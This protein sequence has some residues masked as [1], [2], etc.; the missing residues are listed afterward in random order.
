MKRIYLRNIRKYA[1]VDDEDYE[2]LKQLAW[3]GF[4]SSHDLHYY[5]RAT[6]NH[7]PGRV[8]TVQLHRAV[9]NAQPGEAVTFKNRNRLDCRKENLVIASRSVIRQHGDGWERQRKSKYR[10]VNIRE[11]LTK[12]LRYDSQIRIGATTI[13]LGTFDTEEEAARAYDLAA[14]QHFPRDLVS[15][16]F[17]YR[18]AG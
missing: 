7:G 13:T 18:Q 17:P 11:S 1:L 12:G 10:G 15:L 5:V 9:L 4:R 2:R 14:L 16:N 3:Y 8:E 6:I